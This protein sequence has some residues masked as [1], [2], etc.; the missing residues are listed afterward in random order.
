MGLWGGPCLL[1][2]IGDGCML[3]QG[4]EIQTAARHNLNIVHVAFN[5]AY[6]GA[7]CF[8]IKKLKRVNQ[9]PQHDWELFYK[10]FR[11]GANYSLIA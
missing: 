3:M 10:I 2:V 8:N 7:A 1:V 5:N 9:L 6:Y 11:G 4:V